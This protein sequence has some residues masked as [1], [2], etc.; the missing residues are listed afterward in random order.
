MNILNPVKGKY[1]LSLLL[2]LT[3]L[4]GTKAQLTLQSF[5][6]IGEN[7]VSEGVYLKNMCRSIYEYQKYKV[8]AGILFDLISNNPNALTGIDLT[9]SGE[10]SI[11]NFPFGVKGF[12]MLNRFSDML[13]ETNWGARAELKNLDHII[14]EIGTNFKTYHVNASTREEQDINKSD[15]K[16]RENFNLLYR[17][18]AYLKPHTNN[19]N[20][21]FSVTDFD[22]YVINQST[23]P[24]FNIQASYKPKSNLTIYSELWYKQAGIFNIYAGYFGYF[25]RG[26]LKWEI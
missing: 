19:W 14:F 24:I 11:K 12:F 13:Y 7:N 15:G 16:L 10:F 26:G 17:I 1:L 8:E 9:G 4:T 23:N 25:F 6:D 2:L 21:G 20:L 18:S 22:Y 5:F 3:F